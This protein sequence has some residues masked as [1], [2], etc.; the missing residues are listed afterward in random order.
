ME[1][2]I[3]KKRILIGNSINFSKR[4][5]TYD[6][7]NQKWCPTQFS[8]LLRYLSDD[9]FEYTFNK[10][11]K[12]NSRAL[13]V[14]CIHCHRLIL[15]IRFNYQLLRISVKFDHI[16]CH[17]PVIKQ[18]NNMEYNYALSLKNHGYPKIFKCIGKFICKK[19]RDNLELNSLFFENSYSNF[20]KRLM[21]RIKTCGSSLEEFINSLSEKCDIYVRLTNT[22]PF[23]N[24][25]FSP[26]TQF[27]G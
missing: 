7:Y 26:N 5:D 1:L 3:R 8:K 19:N 12:S 20:S 24:Y 4:V 17:M 14:F 22:N 18:E 11:K 15:V 21:N 13:L 2:I 6:Y 23:L 25:S 27:N 16:C 9:L 10:T